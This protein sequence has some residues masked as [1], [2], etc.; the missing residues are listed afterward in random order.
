MYSN[1]KTIQ[2]TALEIKKKNSFNK[3]KN[4]VTEYNTLLV[5]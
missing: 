2:I 4:K 1:I 3:I 5:C